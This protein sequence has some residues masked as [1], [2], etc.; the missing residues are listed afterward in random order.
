MSRIETSAR[1]LR[2]AVAILRQVSRDDMHQIFG[3]ELGDDLFFG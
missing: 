1:L 3:A 2:D